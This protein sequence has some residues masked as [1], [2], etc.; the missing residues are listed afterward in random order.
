MLQVPAW[1]PYSTA[2]NIACPILLLSCLKD[3]LCL[4]EG[5]RKVA[6]KAKKAELV[7][8]DCGKRRFLHHRN[9]CSTDF[10]GLDEGH[11]DLY[12][13]APFYEQAI[14]AQIEFLKKHVPV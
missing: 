11:F 14:S 1:K 6:E 7:E 3:S 13:T 5:P 9:W 8:Y 10:F 2:A 4:P 12:P